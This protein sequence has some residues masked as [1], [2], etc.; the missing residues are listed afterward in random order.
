MGKSDEQ[1]RGFESEFV[2]QLGR[3]DNAAENLGI[4]IL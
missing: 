3:E 2:M 4:E 1:R